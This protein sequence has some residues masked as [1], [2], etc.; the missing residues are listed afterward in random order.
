MRRIL[1]FSILLIT[2]YFAGLFQELPLLL[3]FL[4]ELALVVALFIESR[5]IAARIRAAFSES[6]LKA[7]EKQPFSCEI[8]IKCRTFLPVLRVRLLLEVTAGRETYRIRANADIEKTGNKSGRVLIPLVPE[9]CGPAK[10]RLLRIDPQDL[11]GLFYGHR[12]CN[13]EMRVAVLPSPV[14]LQI[15][16]SPDGGYPL[17]DSPDYS[18]SGRDNPDQEVRQLHSYQ[19]G[20]LLRYVHWPQS[21]RTGSLMIK[22]F[23]TESIRGLN[24]TLD[25]SDAGPDSLKSM[26]RFFCV[27]SALVRGLIRTGVPVR[28]S[29]IHEETEHRFSLKSE[30]EVEPFF[31]RLYFF[32]PDS[33]KGTSPAEMSGMIL[34][35]DARWY[36]GRH[37]IWSF[38]ET[39]FKKE[40]E[41]KIFTFSSH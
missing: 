4:A 29:W 28:V 22:D 12:K 36:S 10:I 7:F 32:P 11:L 34:T 16:W 33:S 13:S 25:F 8:R 40:I 19:P 15:A 37:L 21:A 26:E 20:D 23:E 27:L 18:V 6:D 35:C 2:F 3:L 31:Q 39:E 24:L 17:P 14:F 38:S 1:F 5:V 41:N 30:A 9:R